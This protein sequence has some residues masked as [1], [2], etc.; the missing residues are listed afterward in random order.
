MTEI[1]QSKSKGTLTCVGTGMRLAGQMTP[2]AKSHIENADVVIGAV[3]NHIS[4][5]WIEG[6]SKEYIC[7]WSYYGDGSDDG[8]N[9]NDTYRQMAD[10][11]KQEVNAG[12]KVC[13]VFYGHPGVFACIGHMAIKELR[14]EGFE[15][16]MLPGISAEDCLV[17]DL[18]IDP[19]ARGAQSMEATQFLINQ[20]HLDASSLVILWQIG[21]VG[22]LSLKRYETSE[23]R[24][25]LL[26]EKLSRTYPLTHEVILYEAATTPLE[27][28]RIDYVP[29]ADLPKQPL[30]QITTLVIPVAQALVADEE[31]RAKLNA[32]GN[33]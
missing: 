16:N 14:A 21:V 26:V 27:K 9:R 10:R 32:L 11:I 18:G 30:S 1:S 7:L 28:T 4:R 24:V 17:A 2:I 8:K 29:L 3:A 19:G 25:A 15:A 22:D 23:T 6:M 31:F 13:A 5:D 33:I 20:R 12:K